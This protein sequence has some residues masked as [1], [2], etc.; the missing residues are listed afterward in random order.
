[1]RR[2]TLI[3]VVLLAFGAMPLAA[4]PAR[5]AEYGAIAWDNQPA[6]AVGARTNPRRSAPMKQPARP[7]ISLGM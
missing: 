1:M 2:S 4:P 7:Q 3:A 5:A 6:N